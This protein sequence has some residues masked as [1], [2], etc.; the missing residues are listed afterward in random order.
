[1]V[2]GTMASLINEG[3]IARR[4]LLENIEKITK[5]R[6]IT[7]VA[8]PNAS[9]NF[10][11][12]NDPIF[13][14]DLFECVGET[15][16][17][18]VI[19][20]SPGGEATIPEKLAIMCREHCKQMRAI[21]INSAKSAATMWA[22]TSDTIL[23]GY[24]SELG[25]ID[26]QIRVVDPRGS[27]T[28]LPAQ[29]IIDGIGAA[30]SMLQQG[31]DQRVVIALMQKLDPALV[32]VAE[33]SIN[34]SKTFAQKWLSQYML[35]DK[36]ELAKGIAEAL[37]DNRRWLT[38]GKLIGIKEAQDL[39][40]K[41]DPIPR[42]SALWRLLWEYYVRSTMKLNATSAAKLFECK[43]QGMQFGMGPRAAPPSGQKQAS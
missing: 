32:D 40:L 39:Q 3:D 27:F 34:F 9:P 1:M 7:Y 21:I 20:D 6:I 18:D 15:E 28:F 4:K 35:K 36:P 12:H 24:L 37:S 31:I 43:T 38:H 10:L 29:S 30:H 17:L 13:L 8:N 25:P 5:N 16:T 11:D 23:M 2:N 41:V 26:P 42:K 14:N 19:I 33:K 22:L